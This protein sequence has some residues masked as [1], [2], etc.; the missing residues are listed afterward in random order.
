M[1][2]VLLKCSKVTFSLST[3]S[4][5]EDTAAASSMAAAAASSQGMR[6]LSTRGGEE[7]LSF[8]QVSERII[9]EA[10]RKQLRLQHHRA[11]KLAQR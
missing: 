4:H 7:R 3:W 8:E 5:S 11:S 10:K 2:E 1:G 6:Y 9:E